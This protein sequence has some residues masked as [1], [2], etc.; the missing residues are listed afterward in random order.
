MYSHIWWRHL[1]R[2]MTLVYGGECKKCGDKRLAKP[3]DKTAAD[4][5]GGESKLFSVHFSDRRDKPLE[6][7]KPKI[8]L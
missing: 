4:V 8:A 1:I 3:S 5:T 6:P 7:R 2:D